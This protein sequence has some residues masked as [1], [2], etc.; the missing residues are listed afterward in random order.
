VEAIAVPTHELPTYN[1]ESR[2]STSRDDLIGSFYKPAMD[3]SVRY[4]RA[5]GFFRSSFFSIAGGP[6]ASFALRGG[7]I[8]LL[9]SPELTEED[10][11]AI[12]RGL[13]LRGLVDQAA[14]RE[15]DRIL[16]YPLARPAV[17]LLAALVAEEALEIRFGMREGAGIFHDKVG[18]FGDRNGNILSF[19]GSVNETWQGWHPLGNHESFEVF[20]SWNA[21]DIPRVD[22]HRAY[23]DGLWSGRVDGLMVY[24]APKA[25]REHLLRFAPVRDRGLRTVTVQT[26]PQPRSLFDHQRLAIENWEAAGCRGILQHATGSGKTLTALHAVRDWLARTGPALVIVP[27]TLLLEQW[28]QEAERELAL[29]EPSI[30]LAGGGHDDW[31]NGALLRVHTE[32]GSSPRLTIAT[33]QTAAS[34]RFIDSVR[35]GDHLL[36]VADEVHRLGST[37]FRRVLQIPSGG[38]LGLSATP[39]RAGDEEGTAA[40]QAYFGDVVPPIVELR[41][42][43]ATGRLCPYEYYVHV[44]DLSEDEAERYI[45]ITRKIGQAFGSASTDHFRSGYLDYLLIERSRIIKQAETKVSAAAEIVVGDYRDG[46]HWL[47]YCDD[48]KQVRKILTLLRHA[49]AAAFE[50]HSSMRGDRDATMNN[51]RVFGGVLVAIRCLDE[52]VDLPEVTHAVIVASSRTTREFIQR[53]GRV[54]RAAPEKRIA[55]IH[56]LLVRPPANPG[57]ERN[58]FS[59]IAEAEVARAAEFARDAVNIATRTQLVGLCIEWDIDPDIL[60]STDADEVEEEWQ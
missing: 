40:I 26:K 57:A 39:I 41:D 44:V 60:L 52:G 42:A 22:A 51:F 21:A 5:V 17:E 38:Q 11:S 16:A 23:F 2:Y 27:S 29:L 46:Q 58:P 28:F 59:S 9:C 15:L 25:F 32:P 6:T 7:T 56:D 43:I 20:L 3:R 10:A 50:Y 55:I 4:D 49:G 30:L 1:W 33:V 13:E 45:E 12:K 36:L 24:D 35:G 14:R 18:I 53:R 54:L 37:T 34:A 31:R 19:S 48:Q 47:V 8:R